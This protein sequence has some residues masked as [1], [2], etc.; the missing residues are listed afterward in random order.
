MKT[1]APKAVTFRT[2]IF[3]AMRAPHNTKQT[4]VEDILDQGVNHYQGQGCAKPFQTDKK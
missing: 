1:R 3:F 2:D 4:T